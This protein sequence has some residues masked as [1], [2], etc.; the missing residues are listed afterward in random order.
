MWQNPIGLPSTQNIAPDQQK[1]SSRL[2]WL[3][4]EVRLVFCAYSIFFAFV[5]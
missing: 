2:F 3:N 1:Q 5:T 4:N